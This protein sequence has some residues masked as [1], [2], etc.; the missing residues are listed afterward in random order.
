VSAKKRAQDTLEHYLVDLHNLNNPD[1]GM[2]ARA[3]VDDIIKASVEEALAKLVVNG[4]DA[5]LATALER[6]ASVLDGHDGNLNI[7]EMLQ[8]TAFQMQ[9]VSG[10][11]VRIADALEAQRDDP[12]AY[13]YVCTYAIVG[14]FKHEPYSVEKYRHMGFRVVETGV[15]GAGDLWYRMR[16]PR[17]EEAQPSQGEIDKAALLQALSAHHAMT[18]E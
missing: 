4:T 18:G 14:D 11:L 17:Q 3:I 5:R 1:C 7:F 15:D 16:R 13:E 12:D 10:S 8:R 2:E 6:I 9:S